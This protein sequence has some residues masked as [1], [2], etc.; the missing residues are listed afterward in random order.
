M[1]T[2]SISIQHHTGNWENDTRPHIWSWKVVLGLQLVMH[3]YYCP[4]PEKTQPRRFVRD[5]RFKF[6][7]DGL[8]IDVAADSEEKNAIMDPAVNKVTAESHAKLMRALS[9]LPE[10]GQALLQLSS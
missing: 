5:H 9:S 7:G 6:Y 10:K 2:E 1:G 4:R 8:F 3:V